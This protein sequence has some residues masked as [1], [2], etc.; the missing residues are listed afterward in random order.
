MNKIQINN[1]IL[2]GAHGFKNE[3]KSKAQRFKIDMDIE[4]KNHRILDDISNTYNYSFAKKISEEVLQSKP[5]NLLETLAE[6]IIERIIVDKSILNVEISIQKLDIWENGIPG[7]KIKRTRNIF[8][9]RLITLDF[10][11][12]WKF[13]IKWSYGQQY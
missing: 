8:N 7:V 2:Y 4:I 13:L 5:L 1:L 10:A 6:R 9:S 3:E 11:K 12:L